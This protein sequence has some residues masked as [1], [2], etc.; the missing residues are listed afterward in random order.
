[1][2][3]GI[4]A[5]LS[6]AVAQSAA[7]DVVAN[8][9]ANASTVGF[10]ARTLSFRELLSEAQ[11]ANET[12]RQV[13]MDGIETDFRAGAIR[14]TGNA[15]D[16]ALSGDGFFVVDVEGTERYTRGGAFMLSNEGTLVTTDGDPVLGEGGAIQVFDS[17]RLRVDEQGRVWSGDAEVGALRVVTFE[18][19]TTLERV[20]GGYWVG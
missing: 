6:G 12:L 17:E 20:G 4:Y 9:V 19:L 5:A 13:E 1:M 16:L 11:A 3:D 8:N 15:T 7:L 14:E 2:A 10:K 18:D